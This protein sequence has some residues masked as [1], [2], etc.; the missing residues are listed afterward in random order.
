MFPRRSSSTLFI[1]PPVHLFEETT[2]M[3]L[4]PHFRNR[5]HQR[6]MNTVI[7][8]TL[9][10]AFCAAGFFGGANVQRL[11]PDLANAI[12]HGYVP[13]FA[14]ALIL[15]LLTQCLYDAIRGKESA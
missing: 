12:T 2:G 14:G 13:Q 11:A 4:A 10:F 9:A 6:K 7:Q 15:G 8:I 1:G 5:H 3:G